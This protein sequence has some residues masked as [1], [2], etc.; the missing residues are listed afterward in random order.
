[1]ALFNLESAGLGSINGKS[2]VFRLSMDG[3]Q[4]LE[5]S[6]GTQR[7]NDT[8]GGGYGVNVYDFSYSTDGTT[9]FPWGTL[10]TGGAAAI[11]NTAFTL[12]PILQSV[13]DADL[14]FVKMTM[15]G[16]TG[17][18]STRVDNIQFNATAIPEPAS[19]A[20]L[21]CGI[22]ILGAGR[23]RVRIA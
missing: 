7:P 15:S 8:N 21:L 23:R 16:A 20:I 11:S 10:A 18:N 14:V 22:G 9:Y 3:Y 6:F 12:S 19:I 5:F 13:N 4:G 1:M 17:F 2:A